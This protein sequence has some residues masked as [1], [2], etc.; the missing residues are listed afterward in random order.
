MPT[1]VVI[2]LSIAGAVGQLRVHASSS[3][4]MAS[5][6]IVG[7]AVCSPGTWLLTER[8]ELIVITHP[9]RQVTVRRLE[10]LR[11][12]DR[13]WGLAC[14][15]DG[16]LWSLA[17]PRVLIRIGAEGVVRERVELRFPR[18][19][20]FGWTDRLLFIDLPLLVA[21]PL[22][23]TAPPRAKGESM[24]WPRFLARATET[25]ADLFARNL[26]NCGIGNDRRLPCWFA[27]E[28]RVVFSDGASAS[29]VSFAALAARDVVAAAPIWDLAMGGADTVWLL[30]SSRASAGAAVSGGRLVKTDGRGT[31]IA[32]LALVASARIIVSATD[33]TCVLL[34][35]DGR[36]MEVIG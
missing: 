30:T 35:V 9:G 18:V 5:S 29:T 31:E 14:L 11:A 15:A 8:P 23:A 16:T 17:T 1:L 36:L 4:L 27:D 33:T 13:P 24:P 6:L 20:V 19:A 7:R 26:V 32:S 2:A 3:P 10:G 22:L 21:K 25:R 12:H 28:R 34:T